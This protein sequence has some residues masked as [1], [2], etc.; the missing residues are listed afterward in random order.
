MQDYFHLNLLNSSQEGIVFSC[1]HKAKSTKFLCTLLCSCWM[2]VLHLWNTQK[3]GINIH[4][5]FGLGPKIHIGNCF[6]NLPPF[7]ADFHMAQRT[8]F[9]KQT[10]KTSAG[11]MELVAR[12]FGPWPEFRLRLSLHQKIP[13]F[14][15][16]K[17]RQMLSLS[18]KLPSYKIVFCLTESGSFFV[19]NSDS[20]GNQ[21]T[22]ISKEQD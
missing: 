19:L 1:S 3:K 20:E 21:S 13:L 16:L 11:R 9:E 10:I 4:T 2:W 18:R 6:W 17:A 8:L 5:E 15:A 7:Q 22:S 14:P 12:Y